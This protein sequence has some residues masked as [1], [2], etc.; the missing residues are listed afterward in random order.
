VFFRAAEIKCCVEHQLLRSISKD[1]MGFKVSQVKCVQVAQGSHELLI[2]EQRLYGATAYLRVNVSGPDGV[3]AFSY[4]E[5]GV[6]FKSIGKPFPA[7]PD[8]WIGAKVGL[9]SV[10]KPDVRLGGYADIDWFRIE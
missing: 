5:D 10:S 8:K 9:Y 3:C 7:Q 6:T 4:S 2:D 1:D